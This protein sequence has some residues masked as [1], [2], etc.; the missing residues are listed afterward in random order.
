MNFLIKKPNPNERFGA[1]LVAMFS[2]SNPDMN[3]KLISLCL[4]PI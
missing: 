1:R 2:P 3:L 4:F